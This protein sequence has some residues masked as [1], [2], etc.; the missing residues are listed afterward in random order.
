M[1]CEKV[2]MRDDLLADSMVYCC[3]AVMMVEKMAA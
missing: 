1:D 3:K 2:V